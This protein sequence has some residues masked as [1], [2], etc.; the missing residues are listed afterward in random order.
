MPKRVIAMLAH[1]SI[2][3]PELVWYLIVI[4]KETKIAVE[5]SSTTKIYVSKPEGSHG[6]RLVSSAIGGHNKAN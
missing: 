2:L 1:P 5:M 3:S 6:V 4:I